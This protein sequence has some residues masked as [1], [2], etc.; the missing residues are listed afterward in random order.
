MGGSGTSRTLHFMSDSGEFFVVAV[1]VNNSNR[2]CD[3]VSSPGTTGL[4]INEEYYN[5]GECLH[6]GEG[7]VQ[8]QCHQR[9]WDHGGGPVRGHC[10]KRFGC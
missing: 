3:V 8:F 5:S 2:W 4:Q 9:C 6:E 7:A 1:G 10:R